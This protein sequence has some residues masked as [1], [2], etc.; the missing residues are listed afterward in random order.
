[1]LQACFGGQFRMTGLFSVLS[2]CLDERLIR[3][4][5]QFDM[6]MLLTNPKYSQSKTF[7]AWFPLRPINEPKACLYPNSPY[8]LKCSTVMG[9]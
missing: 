2:Q 8:A 3:L 6:N 9:L 1:M 4:R 7:H 5:S